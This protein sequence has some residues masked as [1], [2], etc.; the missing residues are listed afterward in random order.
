MERLF[1]HHHL[2]LDPESINEMLHLF[3]GAYQ[4]LQPANPRR[5]LLAGVDGE[6]NSSHI[7]LGDPIETIQVLQ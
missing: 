5:I 3:F 7:A 2:T 1:P 6:L 4:T